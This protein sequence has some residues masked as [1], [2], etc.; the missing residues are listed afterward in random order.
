MTYTLFPY[1]FHPLI[2][3]FGQPLRFGGEPVPLTGKRPDGVL[4]GRVLPAGVG[5][6]SAFFIVFRVGQQRLDLFEAL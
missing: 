6:D 2:K 5:H 4:E 1:L 3:L